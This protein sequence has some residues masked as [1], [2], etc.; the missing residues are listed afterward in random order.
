MASKFNKQRLY[1]EDTI[2]YLKRD[3]QNHRDKIVETEEIGSLELN[4][5]RE[6]LHILHEAEMDELEKKL[7]MQIRSLEDEIGRLESINHGK[8]IE[9]EQLIKDKVTTRGI[10]D[11]EVIRLKDQ[12]SAL[13][14]KHKDLQLRHA[15][16]NSQATNR[17]NDRE[18]HIQ[19][20]QDVVKTQRNNHESQSTSLQKIIDTLKQQLSN[21]KLIYR[22]NEQ[23]M[24]E[25]VAQANHQL[26][27]A[28]THAEIQKA[29]YD[30]QINDLKN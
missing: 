10:F 19:Y 24:K 18:K 14:Q 13:S 26:N 15:D 8:N 21:E 2:A 1:L 3:L 4:Q 5:L 30:K 17:L 16:L 27:E 20:L 11:S 7:I 28:K 25:E 12:L 23:R 22:E 29:S 9:I 6:K